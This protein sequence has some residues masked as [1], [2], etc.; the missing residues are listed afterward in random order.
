MP[1]SGHVDVTANTSVWSFRE[2]FV[3]FLLSAKRVCDT[4]AK[5]KRARRYAR[6]LSA[7]DDDWGIARDRFRSAKRGVPKTRVGIAVEVAETRSFARVVV[8]I[9]SDARHLVVFDFNAMRFALFAAVHGLRQN[10]VTFRLL[11]VT[12]LRR[13]MWAPLPLS[14]SLIIAHVFKLPDTIDGKLKFVPLLI[15]SERGVEHGARRRRGDDRGIVEKIVVPVRSDFNLADERATASGANIDSERSARRSPSRELLARVAVG[16]KLRAR[17]KSGS[18][19]TQLDP[20]DAQR[21]EIVTV[22][23][24]IHFVIL[25]SRSECNHAVS[26][27]ARVR[28]THLYSILV[29]Q[30]NADFILRIHECIWTCECLRSMEGILRACERLSTGSFKSLEAGDV[31]ASNVSDRD[32]FFELDLN[33][34]VFASSFQTKVRVSEVFVSATSTVHRSVFTVHEDCWGRFVRILEAAARIPITSRSVPAPLGACVSV[35]IGPRS[36]EVVVGLCERPREPRAAPR[37]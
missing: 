21:F 35:E 10:L 16:N 30:I 13:T 19:R 15:A 37:H 25:R 2:T 28:A 9:G 7:D 11:T 22:T 32:R 29:E 36:T 1:D 18:V 6:R 5:I 20:I 17:R 24:S 12:A 27:V 3:G 34:L 14:S 8:L 4:D 31:D 26:R 23:N 33:P